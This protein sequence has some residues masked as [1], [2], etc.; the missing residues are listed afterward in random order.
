MALMV[1][2]RLHDFPIISFHVSFWYFSYHSLPLLSAQIPTVYKVC[3]CVF[4]I[5]NK[6]VKQLHPLA[7]FIMVILDVG[8]APLIY[9]VWEDKN[10]RF[11]D[12]LIFY[13]R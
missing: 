9:F 5:V 3:F 10:D 8:T 1:I 12:I 2:I 4:F 6:F 7:L 11:K 13:P